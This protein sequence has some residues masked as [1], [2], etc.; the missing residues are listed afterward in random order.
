MHES[1]DN[2]F[3]IE[4]EL[5]SDA[6]YQI[7]TLGLTANDF[8]GEVLDIGAG[9]AEIAKG[10]KNK[11]DVRV[12]SVDSVVEPENTELVLQQDVRNLQFKDNAFDMVISHAS[13]PHIFIT[14]YD[15]DQPGS[16]S[17]VLESIRQAFSE[18][19]RI[20]KPGGK[21][22]CAPI[23]IAHNYPAETIVANAIKKNLELLREQGVTFSFTKID[24]YTD[25]NTQES[26]EMYRLVIKK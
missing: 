7:E 14:E 24:S 16:E 15:S 19:I 9:D 8:V 6:K 17:H 2:V 5:S 25:I 18:M 26:Y 11:K 4:D 13:M 20:V 22:Y 10:F 23:R 1:S 3:N 21:I 12:V